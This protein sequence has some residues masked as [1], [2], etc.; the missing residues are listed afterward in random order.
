MHRDLKPEN[1]FLVPDAGAPGGERVKVLDFGIAKIRRA[2]WHGWNHADASRTDH[3]Q[4]GVHVAGAV[5][6]QRGRGSALGHLF[7]CDHHLR[8]AGGPDAVC[9]GIGDGDADHASDWDA[10]PLHELVAD[11]PAQVE[12]AIMRA[13]ARARADRFESMAAFVGAL[14]GDAGETGLSRSSSSGELP[15]FRESPVPGA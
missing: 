4:P 1:L 7:L 14:R 8:G 9:G 10:A 6:G 2:R 11:V 5:Q 13:L 15:A 12:A 3:G